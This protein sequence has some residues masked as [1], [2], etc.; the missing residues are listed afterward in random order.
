MEEHYWK[1]RVKLQWNTGYL[2]TMGLKGSQVQILSF[3]PFRSTS[4]GINN[5][6]MG[7]LLFTIE[8]FFHIY[9]FFIFTGK[10]KWCRQF[11]RNLLTQRNSLNSIP[12]ARDWSAYV[13]TGVYYKAIFSMCFESLQVIWTS[14]NIYQMRSL[15]WNY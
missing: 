9:S 6:R 7:R 14:S 10:E 4:I 2:L 3:R 15:K 12:N 1:H 13:L 5:Y 11:K 8:V